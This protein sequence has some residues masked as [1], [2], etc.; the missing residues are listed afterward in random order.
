MSQQ[1]ALSLFSSALS[2]SSPEVEEAKLQDLYAVFESQPS[3]LPIL[4]PSIVPLLDRARPAMRRWVV[5]VMDLA[6]CKGVIN[7]ETRNGCKCNRGTAVEGE[8]WQKGGHMSSNQ[9]AY[10]HL[11]AAALMKRVL[12]SASARSFPSPRQ[13]P[14]TFRVPCS[15][16]SAS[17]VCPT[18]RWRSNALPARTKRFSRQCKW[19]PRFMH[20]AIRH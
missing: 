18:P 17:L 2:A 1:D 6:F 4:F 5:Q 3:N 11:T 14:Y 9:T 19:S 13:W 12:M 20:L 16:T 8:D 15:A 7:I 10:M